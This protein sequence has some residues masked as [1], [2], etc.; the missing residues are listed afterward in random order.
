MSTETKS[1]ADRVVIFDTT[2]RDGEQSPG[3]TMTHEEKLEV[4]EL[5]D[6][7]G[8]DVI[9]AGFPVASE[10]DFAAVR[11]IAQRTKNAVICGL[12]RAGLKDVDRAGEAI[13]PARRGR[14]HT[15]ISTSPVH[16][17]WKLQMEPEKVYEMEIT[18]MTRARGFTDD[19]EWSCEDGTSTEHDFLC[20]CVEA[21]IKAGATTINIPDTVGYTTPDEYRALFE[22]VRT[23]VPNA[24][25]ARFSVHCHNDLGMAVANSLYGVVGGARQVECAINGL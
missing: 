13:R 17:K 10:G 20:R 12:A 5:L 24:D 9:E 23:R 16:M 15:F 14:I 7:M 19:V 4:A 6:A 3:A 11:E 18:S 21:A 2:L 25:K 22:A 8:V 1:E